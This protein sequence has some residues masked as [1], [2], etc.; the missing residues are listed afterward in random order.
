MGNNRLT[1][2][3]EA[4][5]QA[6]ANKEHEHHWEAYAAIYNSKKMSQNTLYQ[7]DKIK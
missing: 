3:Q 1:Q 4:Y 2:K 6:I 7:E 5:S